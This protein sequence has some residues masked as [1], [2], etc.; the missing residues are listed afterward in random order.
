MR[1]EYPR[2]NMVRD[3]F[4]N[5]NTEWEFEFDDL[6]VGHKEKWFEKHDFSK[7]IN[8]PFAF[9]S[10]LSGIEDPS[11]HDR[12]W[13]K[14]KFNSEKLLETED[15]LLHLEGVD[16]YSEVYLNGYLLKY[17]YGGH[18]GYEVTLTDYLKEGENELVV[19]AFDPS[20]DRRIHRG[21]QDWELESHAIWYTRTSGI[22]KPVWMEKVS[23]ERI[24]QFFITTKLEN[25]KINFDLETTIKKGNLIFEV[26]DENRSLEY[27][28]VINKDKDNYSFELPVKFVNNRLWSVESPFLF[29][30]KITLLND[31]FE[32]VD[33][34][35]TYFG[36]R[37][38]TT[39]DHKVYLNNK[40][41]YQKLVLNQGYFKDGILT[42]PTKEDLENDLKYMKEMG[43]NGCRIH[44][45]SED[46]YFLYLADKL[47]FLIWQECGANYEYSNLSP[48]RLINEWI[49]IIKNN[50]NHPSIIVYTPFNESWGIENIYNNKEITSHVLSLYYLI[51]SIDN[52]RLVISNDG[53]EHAKTDLL[54]IHNYAH[55]NKDEVEKFER[56]KFNLSNRENILSFNNINRYII[57]PGFKDEDQPVLLTEF[58]GIAFKKDTNEL[59]WGYT[60]SSSEEEYIN[61]LKRIYGAIKESST[62]E[63]ICYTQF[64]D[65]EQ[66]VNGLMT[67]DR[68]FKVDPKIIKSINDMLG[69]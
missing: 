66:E 53:W 8:V 14:L 44:Q 11:F 42:A 13:Y 3:S 24:K 69:E 55:G 33:E 35:S 7:K 9:Q 60:T 45:K 2:M 19:F 38:I 17:H 39:K 20:S 59:A 37:E 61:D 25:Y 31:Q 65:V 32:K 15:L 6:N 21:K 48:R 46:Q 52:T 23:K 27:K 57:N 26:K 62:I 16:Y 34:V 30:V 64:T 12:V 56:F 49:E 28:F 22:Y 58:G 10:K 43:F 54:T 29:D 1:N 5:L 50:F 18:I 36:I 47:G 63:G 51:K 40:R 68:Q 41:I 4:I 67:Y